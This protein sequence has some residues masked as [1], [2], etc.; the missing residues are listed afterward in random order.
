M[1]QGREAIK[2]GLAGERKKEIT[3]TER[4]RDLVALRFRSRGRV[5]KRKR[6]PRLVTIKFAFRSNI[7][8]TA[9]KLIGEKKKKSEV[10]EREA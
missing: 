4:E 2:P 1:V 9:F 7:I 5:R 3:V 10:I 6:N 8:W